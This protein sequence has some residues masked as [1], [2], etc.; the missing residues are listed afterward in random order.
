MYKIDSKFD[1]E[2]VVD[3][4]NKNAINLRNADTHKEL[5]RNYYSTQNLEKRRMAKNR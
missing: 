5:L 2:H 3:E 4:T 1:A